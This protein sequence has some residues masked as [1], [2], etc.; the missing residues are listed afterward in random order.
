ME[1]IDRTRWPLVHRL[2]NPNPGYV[3]V[4][5]GNEWQ[6]N[7][8]DFCQ[9]GTA[10]QKKVDEKKDCHETEVMD[11][12]WF[13]TSDS[14]CE[15]GCG[16]SIHSYSSNP[17]DD[18]DSD[19]ELLKI[20]STR[21]AYQTCNSNNS[22]AVQETEEK[23]KVKSSLSKTRKSYNH[24]LSGLDRWSLFHRYT[25]GD[26]SVSEESR[27]TLEFPS[28]SS[29]ERDDYWRYN[30]L[31]EYFRDNEVSSL[32]KDDSGTTT[33]FVSDFS[34]SFQKDSSNTDESEE[35]E[36]EYSKP[37]GFEPSQCYINH[38]ND[39]WYYRDFKTFT[40]EERENDG[41]IKKFLG[42]LNFQKKLK[43]QSIKRRRQC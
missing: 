23:D 22:S 32:D 2:I 21:T 1:D 4:K 9:F 33:G 38:A 24:P 41:V 36:V 28:S 14:D 8:R 6:P 35:K 12:P 30:P 31:F 34:L 10:I 27:P 5:G 18:S 3:Y 42:Y 7:Y 17:F 25:S 20:E 39:D 15:S 13:Q 29:E 19:Q 11:S 40:P 43:M 16:S 37:V 26:E